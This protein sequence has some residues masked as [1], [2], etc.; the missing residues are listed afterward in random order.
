MSVSRKAQPGLFYQLSMTIDYTW[1]DNSCRTGTKIECFIGETRLPIWKTQP[2]QCL[3]MTP[4][5]TRGVNKDIIIA[6]SVVSGLVVCGAVLL[7]LVVLWLRKHRAGSGEAHNSTEACALVVHP[8]V[9]VGEWKQKEQPMEQ[10]GLWGTKPL[11]GT[12][13][14]HIGHNERLENCKLL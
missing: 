7:S 9:T 10:I 5:T 8:I 11:T 12:N 6:V 4:E 3:E 1:E 2:D 13:G 14:I